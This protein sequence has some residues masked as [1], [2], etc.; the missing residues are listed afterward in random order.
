MFAAHNYRRR[1]I[2]HTIATR[3]NSSRKAAKSAK[4]A[5]TNHRQCVFLFDKNKKDPCRDDSLSQSR[6]ERK[7]CA[8]ESQTMRIPI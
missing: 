6:K 5:P 4:S 3:V 8:N 7:V 1:V 2:P